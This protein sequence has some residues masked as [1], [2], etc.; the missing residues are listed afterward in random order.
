MT[1]R[2]TGSC[3]SA[4][5]SLCPSFTGYTWVISPVCHSTLCLCGPP[6]A[7]SLRSDTSHVRCMHFPLAL[8]RAFVPAKIFQGMYLPV[9][10]LLF[11]C[12][13]LAARLPGLLAGEHGWPAS[14][15]AGT[16]SYEV[17]SKSCIFFWSERQGFLRSDSLCSPGSD[18]TV[19]LAGAL[20]AFSGQE[21]SF[22]LP[23]CLRSRFSWASWVVVEL[24]CLEYQ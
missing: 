5:A 11:S 1:C 9:E 24:R 7:A 16:R 2:V 23:L 6:G 15:T 17:L 8:L 18:L 21:A 19:L 12:K 14:T 13:S 3:A 4:P 22:F 10:T 20:F